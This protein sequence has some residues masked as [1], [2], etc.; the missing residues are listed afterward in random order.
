MLRKDL[1]HQIIL[2]NIAGTPRPTSGT[3]F[4]LLRKAVISTADELFPSLLAALFIVDPF[5]DF[6]DRALNGTRIASKVIGS[7]SSYAA[8][9]VALG[10][11]WVLV[12]DDGSSVRSVVSTGPLY[13]HEIQ[14]MG[15]HL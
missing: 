10:G 8:L 5:F 12:A 14:A 13:K 9:S 2:K 1:L 4:P 3:S 6:L 15:N 7:Q 11:C